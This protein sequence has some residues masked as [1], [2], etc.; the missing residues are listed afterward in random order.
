MIEQE[1]TLRFPLDVVVKVRAE[2]S[3]DAI[4][5]ARSGLIDELCRG[6][7]VGWEI[8]V[9]DPDITSVIVEER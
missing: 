9:S 3:E 2:T 7:L 6:E 1:Y 4:A 5:Y 8:Y